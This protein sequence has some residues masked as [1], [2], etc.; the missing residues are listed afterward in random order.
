MSF[1]LDNFFFLEKVSFSLKNMLFVLIF[2]QFIV[3]L[4]GNDKYLKNLK[5]QV[6]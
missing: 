2:N 6:W 4:K 5:F 3:I 1:L